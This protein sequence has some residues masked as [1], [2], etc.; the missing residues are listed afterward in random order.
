MEELS[1][2]FWLTLLSMFMGGGA[3]PAPQAS[4]PGASA[5]YLVQQLSYAD[6]WSMVFIIE[7]ASTL[8]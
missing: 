8:R 5:T 3:E 4:P 7:Q 1:E 6:T 2:G